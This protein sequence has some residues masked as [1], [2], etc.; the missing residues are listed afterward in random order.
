MQVTRT[1]SRPLMTKSPICAEG[2]LVAFN[3]GIFTR[4]LLP[5]LER[6]S[7]KTGIAPSLRT[8]RMIRHKS[9]RWIDIGGW[10]N[11]NLYYSHRSFETVLAPFSLTLEYEPRQRVSDCD[12]LG[13]LLIPETEILS[14]DADYP[15][16]LATFRSATEHARGLKHISLSEPIV[17][18]F[19]AA[20]D[21]T[22]S[23][24]TPADSFGESVPF[25]S[26]EVIRLLCFR[27]SPLSTLNLLTRVLKHRSASWSPIR[28][29]ESLGWSPPE[30][31]WFDELRAIVPIVC[32]HEL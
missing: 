2:I 31:E 11:S 28:K 26:L 5:V 7:R 13:A 14:L 32:W 3:E 29:V 22:A 6:Q 27:S 1:F 9:S 25:P 12:I 15:C 24:Q 30:E 23:E 17:P 21:T 18:L 16:D 8:I 20:M 19:C 4:S 10:Q